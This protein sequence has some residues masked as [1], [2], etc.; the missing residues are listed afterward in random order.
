MAVVFGMFFATHINPGGGTFLNDLSLCSSDISDCTSTS[1]TADVFYSDHFP[2]SI[3]IRRQGTLESVHVFRSRYHWDNDR[4]SLAESLNLS[5]PTFYEDFLGCCRFALTAGRRFQ[6]LTLPSGAPK[7]AFLLGQ[8]RQF[9]PGLCCLPPTG[10]LIIGMTARLKGEIR[11]A[12]RLYW[13]R[14]YDGA[15]QRR[16]SFQ[17][18]NSLRRTASVHPSSHLLLKLL[19]RYFVRFCSGKLVRATF[20]QDGSAGRPSFYLWVWCG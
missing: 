6:C 12:T 2:I 5:A 17:H 18:L 1:V 10:P 9:S 7:C 4:L 8:K 19:M 11:R 13:Q 15:A 20:Q 3:S 16:A 14:L